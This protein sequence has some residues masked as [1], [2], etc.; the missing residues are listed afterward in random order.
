MKNIGTLIKCTR[1]LKGLSQTQ[2]AHDICSPKYIYLIEKS[3][4]I[5]SVEIL[6]AIGSRMDVDFFEYLPYADC[7]DPIFVKF[8]IDSF[9][10]SRRTYNF[11]KLEIE[12]LKAQESI[13]FKN[14]PWLG[15][16]AYNKAILQTFNHEDYAGTIEILKPSISELGANPEHGNLHIKDFS[17]VLARLYNMLFISYMKSGLTSEAYELIDF[18]ALHLSG[19]KNIQKYQ[20]IYISISQ[21]YIKTLYS[22]CLYANQLSACED[23]ISLQLET[24]KT[25]RLYLTTFLKALALNAL[26]R[27][28]EGKELLKKTLYLGCGIGEEKFLQVLLRSNNIR[29][30]FLEEPCMLDF[31]DCILEKAKEV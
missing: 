21:N 20:D 11:E 26:D 1:E 10:I 24:S 16:I 28:V 8:S 3:E 14:N 6:E 22:R 29:N 5:P 4:R 12:T 18:L 17:P 15:E 13:D 2:L 25:D 30:L 31:I 19:K 7:Y 27:N 23:L 9:N